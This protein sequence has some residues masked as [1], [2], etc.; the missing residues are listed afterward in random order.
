MPHLRRRNTSNQDS[1][2]PAIKNITHE[3]S[4][5]SRL[6]DIGYVDKQAMWQK[7]VNIF[8]QN[9]CHQLGIKAIRLATDLFQ[10]IKQGRHS[11]SEEPCVI[12]NAGGSYQLVTPNELVRY[13]H[14]K[15]TL[16]F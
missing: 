9:S 7:I 14:Y 4:L 13:Y 6:G 11:S 5:T 12:L 16:S 3:P 15:S 2:K 10:Y 1:I 8:D